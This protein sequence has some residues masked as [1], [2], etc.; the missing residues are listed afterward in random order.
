MGGALSGDEDIRRK[1]RLFK[2]FVPPGYFENCDINVV[3]ERLI[4]TENLL[5]TTNL[6]H[7]ETEAQL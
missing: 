4:E 1:E 6:A 3:C 7:E 2:N 5:R